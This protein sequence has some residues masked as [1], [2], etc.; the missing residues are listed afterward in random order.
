[1]ASS[2]ITADKNALLSINDNTGGNRYTCTTTAEIKA[3][4]ADMLDNTPGNSMRYYILSTSNA[5]ET[6]L[7][8]KGIYSCVSCK[9]STSSVYGAVFFFTYGSSSNLW[10]Y[11]DNDHTE[12]FRYLFQF[13]GT[14]K[15]QW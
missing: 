9:T 5:T 13:G 14:Q 12:N 7:I 6:D 1:M 8:P 15:A 11:K 3:A 2:T 10:L 4:L